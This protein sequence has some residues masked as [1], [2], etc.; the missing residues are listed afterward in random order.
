MMPWTRWADRRRGRQAIRL[1]DLSWLVDDHTQKLGRLQESVELLSKR[2]DLEVAAGNEN[3]GVLH[4]KAAALEHALEGQQV[5]IDV[6][7]NGLEELEQRCNRL[8]ERID[9]VVITADA[10]YQ[11]R[12]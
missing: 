12:A 11:D 5:M 3:S 10:R 7:A 8:G 2:V 6:H 1:N 9:D 4:D